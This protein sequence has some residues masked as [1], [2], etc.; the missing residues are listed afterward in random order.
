MIADVEILGAWARGWAVSRA[1]PAPVEEPDG[2]RVDVGLPGHRVRYLLRS[3]S[4]V[5][6]RARTVASPG[7]WLKTCGSRPAVLAGLTAEWEVGETEYLMTFEGP[8]PI[9]AA[10]PGYAVTVTGSDPRWDVAVSFDGVLAAR[11]RVAVA[12]GVAVFDQIETEPE[13]RR[14]GLG[15]VVMH[16]LAAAAGAKTG[17]LLAT[18]AGRG[19]YGSLGWQVASELVPAHVPEGAA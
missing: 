14:R 7:T 1:V 4:T 18:E 6:A 3:P 2:H 17:A 8:V 19:L 15:R 13:H 9:A 12:S 11:G 10:P 5:A 16:R